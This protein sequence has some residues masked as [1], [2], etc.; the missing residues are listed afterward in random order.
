M[1]RS[2]DS[3]K[4]EAESGGGAGARQ[5]SRSIGSNTDCAGGEPYYR[6]RDGGGACLYVPNKLTRLDYSCKQYFASF[7]NIIHSEKTL[8]SAFF[9]LKA[10]F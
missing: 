2:G 1:S 10:A 3:D 4:K 6:Y 7:N 8:A 5:G 9:F